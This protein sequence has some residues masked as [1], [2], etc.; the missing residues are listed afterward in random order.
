MA[1]DWVTVHCPVCKERLGE[2]VKGLLESFECQTEGCSKTKH[3][4]YPGET[5]RPGKS[6]PWFSYHEEKNNCKC[7]NCQARK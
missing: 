7:V 5:Q 1:S 2:K 6:T 3:Y 4:F